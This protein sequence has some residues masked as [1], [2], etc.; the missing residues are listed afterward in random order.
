MDAY[1]QDLARWM[2]RLLAVW[3]AARKLPEGPPALLPKELK[4]VAAGVRTL[5]LGLT[6]ERQL[7]GARYMDDPRLLG[8]YLLF[9]WPV[10]YAQGRQVLGELPARARRVLD[11]GSGPGPLA[12]AALDAGAAEVTAADRSRPALALAREL[13]AEASEALATREWDPHR[14]GELP[15]TSLDAVL[16]GHLLN[17]LFGHGEPALGRRAALVERALA[18]LRP[19]GSVVLIEPA[20]R[21]TSR[22]L[23]QL[24]DVLVRRGFAVRAPCLFR[25]DCPALTKPSDWCHAERAWS[26]PPLLEQLARAAGLHKEALK[27]SYLVLAPKG[28]PWREPPAGRS[29]RIVSE[30]LE[31]KGRQRFMACGPEGRLGLALQEK[32]R[33]A[34]NASFFRLARG[35]VVRVSEAEPRGDGLSLTER[36][37]VQVL[38]PAGR[39]LETDG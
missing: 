5:S 29:F 2:P 22:E 13:A 19:G 6:R 38:A 15:A 28:E 27:M 14:A 26:M 32:H 25:G 30:P 20:L 37:E 12:F 10:S 7:A 9:Y 23:L 4:E 36:S 31:G 8:A 24:R 18:A 3:R 35:D 33:T 11:L 17:E 1:A 34:Q 16:M 39:P 21:E